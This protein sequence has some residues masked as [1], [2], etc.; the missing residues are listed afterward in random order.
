MVSLVNPIPT[1]SPTK[2][3]YVSVLKPLNWIPGN[4]KKKKTLHW[5][6]CKNYRLKN[7]H[8]PV[9]A[10]IYCCFSPLRP[11]VHRLYIITTRLFYN[12]FKCITI[13]FFEA[14]QR[15]GFEKY[16]REKIS[17]KTLAEIFSAEIF[18]RRKFF[19]RIS[20]MFAEI[21]SAEIFPPKFFP[22]KILGFNVCLISIF[23]ILNVLYQYRIK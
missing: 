4:F 11:I 15:L 8:H 9:S 12:S 1:S 7:T 18:S 23:S 20:Q 17:A 5:E 3:L 2:C 10:K 14:S 19:R 16:R 21:F 6:K 22:P 13:G